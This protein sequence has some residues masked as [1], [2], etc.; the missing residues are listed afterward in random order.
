MPRIDILLPVRNGI[1]FLAESLDSVR[2]QTFKD[3]RLIVLDHGSSDGSRELAAKYQEL[4][5]RIELHSFPDAVGLS[6]LLNKGIE[7]CDCEFMMRHDADDVCF[8]DRMAVTLAAFD[9]DPSCIAIGGQA[10]VINATGQKIGDMRMP[11]GTT[12]VASASLFHNPIAHPTAMLRFGEMKN[13][14]VIYGVDFMG[15]LPERQ[16]IVVPALAED[17]FLFGQLAIL[18]KCNNLPNKLI[19]YRWHGNNVSATKFDDQMKVS[20]LI[21]RYLV[22]SFCKMNS[23]PVF[24]PVPF[25]NHGGIIFGFDGYKNFDS[26]FQKMVEILRRGFNN[27]QEIERELSFRHVI[28]A[29]NELVL[30]AR[31]LKFMVACR[32]ESGEWNAVRSWIIRNFPGKP[33]MSMLLEDNS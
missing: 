7:L 28:S 13:R 18:G 16:R 21:S 15:V 6:G 20:L 1:D 9:N 33:K 31:Y 26:E 2:N 27:S 17:Y 3:W 4:D 14:G 30:L 23:L 29:R 12:R 5:S 8:P 25:C 22:K 19:Q 32:P 24:D 11:I 10:N